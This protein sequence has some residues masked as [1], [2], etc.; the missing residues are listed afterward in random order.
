MDKEEKIE[1]LGLE[2][3]RDQ[4]NLL[5]AHYCLIAMITIGLFIISLSFIK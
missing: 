4:L 1:I 3:D 5:I 2:I